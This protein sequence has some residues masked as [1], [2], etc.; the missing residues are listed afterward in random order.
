LL[1][2]LNHWLLLLNHQLLLLQLNHQLLLLQLLS[3]AVAAPAAA[4]DGVLGGLALCDEAS[5]FQGS[6]PQV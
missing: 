5:H 6:V 3:R 1:L 4:Q 2:L